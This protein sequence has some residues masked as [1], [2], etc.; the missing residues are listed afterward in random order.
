MLLVLVQVVK[1]RLAVSVPML[2][3]GDFLYEE[4]E[5]LDDDEVEMYQVWA[6][7]GRCGGNMNCCGPG[8]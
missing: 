1:K 8:R 2:Q 5:G 4:G 7:V 6:G 3:C